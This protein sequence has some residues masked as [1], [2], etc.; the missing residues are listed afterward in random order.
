MSWWTQFNIPS[1]LVKVH[2]HIRTVKSSINNYNL[3]RILEAHTPQ[4]NRKDEDLPRSTR[5]N[6]YL[7]LNITNQLSLDTKD[8]MECSTE[9]TW[10]SKLL[11]FISLLLKY[12]EPMTYSKLSP[13]KT[14]VA[15]LSKEIIFFDVSSLAPGNSID[16]DRW[17]NL[18]YL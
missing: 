3:N 2:P 1:S 16:D 14:L 4:I 11:P 15:P 7:I 9:V 12:L 13:D 10:S 5:C 18:T 8:P 17:L 6:Y